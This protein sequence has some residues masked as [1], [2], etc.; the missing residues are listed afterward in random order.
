MTIPSDSVSSEYDAVLFAA[1]RSVRYHRC[2]QA[3]FDRVHECGLIFTALS[4]MAV[5]AVLLAD[6]PAG[7]T[8]VR[9][10]AAG[11]TAFGSAVEL[12]FTPARRAR[13]HHALAGRFLGL[14]ADL[15]RAGSSVAP[16][17]LA[18]IQ[19]SR[20]EIEASAPPVLRVL[21]AICHDELVTA[22]G[23]DRSRRRDIGSWQRLW[24][25]FVDVGAHRLRR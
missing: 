17:A 1:R 4:A 19:S 24:R 25:H 8:W 3:F 14:E 16:Q 7:W 9:L 5:V 13:E 20:L 23:L 18:E 2:R 15:L 10:G 11:L 22:L 6:L 12:L 21:D